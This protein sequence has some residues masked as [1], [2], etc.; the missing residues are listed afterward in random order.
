MDIF[1]VLLLNTLL[2]SFFP[3]L[4]LPFTLGDMTELTRLGA[5]FLSSA[6]ACWAKEPVWARFL[7]SSLVPKIHITLWQ[8]KAPIKVLQA[9]VSPPLPV[10]TALLFSSPLCFPH[11]AF[12]TFLVHTSLDWHLLPTLFHPI[13]SH[14]VHEYICSVICPMQ[15]E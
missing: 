13:C 8:G 14:L 3:S 1:R 12:S 10:T 11:P 6:G 15:G 5:L 7:L 4:K 9:R 2:F